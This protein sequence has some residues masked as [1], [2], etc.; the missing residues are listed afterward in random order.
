MNTQPLLEPYFTE[1]DKNLV[2]VKFLKIGTRSKTA[3][4]ILINGTVD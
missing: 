3:V 1:T 4:N 2:T